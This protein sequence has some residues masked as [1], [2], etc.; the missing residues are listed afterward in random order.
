MTV[1]ELSLSYLEQFDIQNV[2]AAKH[3]E[4][5]VPAERLIEFNTQIKDGIWI[6]AAYFGQ[7]YSSKIH[8]S[9]QY[10]ERSLLDLVV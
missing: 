1:F 8:Q 2:G 7:Q 6:Q 3:N 10:L 5:W 4:L 9:Q